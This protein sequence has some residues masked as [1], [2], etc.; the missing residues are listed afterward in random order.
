MKYTVST[1]IVFTI[2]SPED[3]IDGFRRAKELA[4]QRLFD[5]GFHSFEFQGI[6]PHEDTD[7]RASEGVGEGGSEEDLRACYA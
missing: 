3:G 6:L 2:D 5:A 4:T 7:A 1:T